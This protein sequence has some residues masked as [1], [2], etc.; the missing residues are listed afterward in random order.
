MLLAASCWFTTTV[1]TDGIEIKDWHIVAVAYGA[2]NIVAAL[3]M[4]GASMKPQ[5]L[6]RTLMMGKFTLAAFKAL[7]LC[8]TNAV[9]VGLLTFQARGFQRG[10]APLPFVAPDANIT[11]GLM[12]T[13]ATM[14]DPRERMDFGVQR[15]WSAWAIFLAGFAALVSVWDEIKISETAKPCLG[16]V[17]LFMSSL[18]SLIGMVK[19]FRDD[20]KNTEEGLT[21]LI[22]LVVSSIP[23]TLYK[24]AVTK[25]QVIHSFVSMGLA[26]SMFVYLTFDGP[27]VEIGNLYFGLLIAGFAS[28]YV[29]ACKLYACSY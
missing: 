12:M 14:I 3:S 5:L 8:I 6:S 13:N 4:I 27:V 29:Y 16:G 28:I 7:H 25:A 22:V 21:L 23:L 20:A 2:F 17:I 11:S 1:A 18:V 10:Y 26:V 24:D 15:Y 9:F 19:P